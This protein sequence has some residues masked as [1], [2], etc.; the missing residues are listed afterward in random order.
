[1][2]AHVSDGTA[3][4]LGNKS[5]FRSQ[6][7]SEYEKIAGL[8]RDG[9]RGRGVNC[10]FGF[11][12]E[13]GERRKELAGYGGRVVV[14][15]TTNSGECNGLAHSKVEQKFVNKRAPCGKRS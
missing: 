13:S 1:M 14:R 5:L 11:V 2:H 6:P 10:L 9:T 4:E 12:W 3:S 8:A 7:R 15:E